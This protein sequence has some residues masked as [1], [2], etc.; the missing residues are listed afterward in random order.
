MVRMHVLAPSLTPWGGI[1]VKMASLRMAKGGKLSHSSDVV[2][3]CT[4]TAVAVLDCCF[5]YLLNL[6]VELDIPSWLSNL[7]R[8]RYM[9]G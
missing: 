4:C 5:L 8:A 6:C 9:R 1:G 3:T 7:Q 2:D